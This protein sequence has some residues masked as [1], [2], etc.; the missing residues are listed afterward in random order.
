MKRQPVLILLILFFVIPVSASTL[1]DGAFDFVSTSVDKVLTILRDPIY[2]KESA[3][4]VQRQKLRTVVEALFDYDE[5]SIRVLGRE[6]KSFT[7][8]QLDEF[9]DLFTRLME[10]VYLNRI[11]EYSDEKVIYGKATILSENKAEVETNVVTASKQIPIDYR[12]VYKHGEWRGYDVFIEGVSLVKNYRS[13][14]SKILQNKTPEDLLQQLREKVNEEEAP[15][16]K[17]ALS[18]GSV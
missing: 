9:S 10:K 1:A 11:Q 15:T 16:K 13:Q 2:K 7:P 17:A 8:E 12:V 5:I 4:E 6:R 3:R 18:K 14:F